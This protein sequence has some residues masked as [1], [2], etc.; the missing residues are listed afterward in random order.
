M[1]FFCFFL[2]DMKHFPGLD[3]A[4]RAPLA[5]SSVI[6]AAEKIG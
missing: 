3:A 4:S 5:S 1:V 2:N 6:G